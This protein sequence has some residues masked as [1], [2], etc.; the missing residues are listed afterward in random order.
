MSQAFIL[1]DKACEP[2]IVVEKMREKRNKKKIKVEV[3]LKRQN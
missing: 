2:L 1:L 3:T